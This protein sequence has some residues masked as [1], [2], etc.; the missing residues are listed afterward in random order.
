MMRNTHSKRSHD[1]QPVLFR[2][3]SVSDLS[4]ALGAGLSS[5]AIHSDAGGQ[6]LRCRL[7]LDCSPS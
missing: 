5:V 6:G 4:V 3:E 2:P 1:A 7:L